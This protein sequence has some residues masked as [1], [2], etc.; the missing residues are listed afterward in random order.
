MTAEQLRLTPRIVSRI[1]SF[2]V[3]LIVGIGLSQL[4]PL[5][6]QG[7]Q[8]STSE[9]SVEKQMKRRCRR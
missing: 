6:F 7:V 2:L 4:I 3:T 8:N 1:V 5:R 9:V